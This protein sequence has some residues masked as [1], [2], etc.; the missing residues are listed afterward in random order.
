MSAIL[1]RFDRV[2]LTWIP[3]ER[4]D[5]ISAGT[6]SYAVIV[7]GS[8]SNLQP[9][10]AHTHTGRYTDGRVHRS[11]RKAHIGGGRLRKLDAGKGGTDDV[12]PLPGTS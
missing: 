1:A 2:T 3:R 7:P 11:I 6:P 12:C 8:A 9:F 5:L 4:E 10:F